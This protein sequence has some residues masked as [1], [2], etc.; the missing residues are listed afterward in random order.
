MLISQLRSAKYNNVERYAITFCTPSTCQAKH[1]YWGH[2]LFKQRTGVLLM[3]GDTLIKDGLP[4]II[5]TPCPRALHEQDLRYTLWRVG[6]RMRNWGI[7][8]RNKEFLWLHGRPRSQRLSLLVYH[9]VPHVISSCGIAFPVRVHA[10]S[11]SRT[12]PTCV[13]YSGGG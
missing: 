2:G 11:S 3:A 1:V 8:Y 12:R 4:V 6:C 7:V 9:H 13:L 5:N 10:R